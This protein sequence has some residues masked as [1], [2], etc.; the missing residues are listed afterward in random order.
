MEKFPWLLWCELKPHIHTTV[1]PLSGKTFISLSDPNIQLSLSRRFLPG[2]WELVVSSGSPAP[3]VLRLFSSSPA[4]AG[5]RCPEELLPSVSTWVAVCVSR[6]LART[7]PQLVCFLFCSSGS[8]LLPLESSVS[9]EPCLHR[10]HPGMLLAI[11]TSDLLSLSSF[12][13][14][15]LP[16]DLSPLTRC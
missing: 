14:V 7:G 4:P 11:V 9:P 6:A 16:F 10:C 3:S 5:A 8:V 2:P 15:L 12:W 13:E 1:I